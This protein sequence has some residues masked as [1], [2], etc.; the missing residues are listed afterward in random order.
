MQKERL[1]QGAGLNATLG[2]RVAKQ[3]EYE[4]RLSTI[5]VNSEKGAEP[6]YDAV[7][8]IK[9]YME[10]L[11]EEDPTEYE[12]VEKIGQLQLQIKLEDV[13]SEDVEEDVASPDL[14]K[15]AESAGSSP[16]F[17]ISPDRKRSK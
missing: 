3:L 12:T 9:E 5:D 2:N 10:M 17:P 11:Q 16:T 7:A 4:L 15:E 1:A 8:H 14:Q 6:E 13:A